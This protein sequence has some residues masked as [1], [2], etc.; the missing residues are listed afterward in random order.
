MPRPPGHLRCPGARTARRVGRDQPGTG[1]S[2]GRDPLCRTRTGGH[3]VRPIGGRRRRAVRGDTSP[4]ARA[5]PYRLARGR[6]PGSGVDCDE[7]LFLSRSG[8]DS[9]RGGRDDR[10]AGTADSLGGLQPSTGRL[11]VGAAGLRRG[12]L[13]RHRAGAPRR[14]HG[15]LSLRGGC[16]SGVG[17]SIF[18]PRPGRAPSFHGSTG[19]PSRPRWERWRSRLWR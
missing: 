18:S 17:P 7:H 14:R 10:S 8:P 15:R 11:A 16:G 1:R 12:G 6:R 4:V 3:G 19:W 5:D 2:A 9:P 13:A